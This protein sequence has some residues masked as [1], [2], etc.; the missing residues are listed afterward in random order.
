MISCYLHISYMHPSSLSQFPLPCLSHSLI[1][2]P[3]DSPLMARRVDQASISG[4]VTPSG[5]ASPSED[6]TSSPTHSVK[7]FI[8]I[9]AE[10]WHEWHASCLYCI[11]LCSY[12]CI[13]IGYKCCCS[14]SVLFIGNYSCSILL[15]IKFISAFFYRNP[16]KMQSL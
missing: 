3:T 14:I 5:H 8:R 9:D 2:W 11:V 16:P 4:R 12:I 6:R 7:S 1:L 13:V 10:V 15:Q